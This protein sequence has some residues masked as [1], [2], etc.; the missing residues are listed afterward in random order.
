MVLMDNLE[1]QK[2][3]ANLN[4][5]VDYYNN[6]IM[7][8]IILRGLDPLNLPN[9]EKKLWMFNMSKIDIKE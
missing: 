2:L 4:K 3:N 5:L 1:T 7:Q 9:T 6:Q 8:F